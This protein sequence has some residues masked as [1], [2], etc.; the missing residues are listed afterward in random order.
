MQEDP[1][2]VTRRQ[3]SCA[4]CDWSKIKSQ[5]SRLG[6]CPREFLVP[7][8]LVRCSQSRYRGYRF[9]VLAGLVNNLPT[10]RASFDLCKNLNDGNL[11]FRN[12]TNSASSSRD[13]IININAIS[14]LYQYCIAI[15]SVLKVARVCVK[16]YNLKLYL[17]R[18]N[19]CSLAEKAPSNNCYVIKRRTVNNCALLSFTF[20]A[21]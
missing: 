18:V 14:H 3:S 12:R 17:L 19:V 6:V 2:N 8:I 1:S 7:V 4:V 15:V 16:V 9:P 13:C 21:C 11:N 10:S 20:M 5:G